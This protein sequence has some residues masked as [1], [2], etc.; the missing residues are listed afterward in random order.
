MSVWTFADVGEQTSFQLEDGRVVTAKVVVSTECPFCQ[1]K[2]VMVG[3]TADGTFIGAHLEP[4]CVQFYGLELDEY[5]A[6][7]RDKKQRERRKDLS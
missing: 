7:I 5:L 3:E 1:G 4:H 2:P 6:A